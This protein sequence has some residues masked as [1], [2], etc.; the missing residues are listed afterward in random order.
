MF[1]DYLKTIHANQYTGTDDNMSDD[2]ENWL[3][4][5]EIDEIIKLAD[6]FCASKIKKLTI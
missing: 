3:T 6:D 4:D 1:E 2:F 5:L